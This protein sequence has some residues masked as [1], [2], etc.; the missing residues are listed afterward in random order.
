M[1]SE[2]EREIGSS[3][4]PHENPGDLV[5]NDKWIEGCKKR[6]GTLRPKTEKAK[7]EFLEEATRTLKIGQEEL[8]VKAKKQFRDNY[9]EEDEARIRREEAKI[10]AY[11]KPQEYLKKAEETAEAVLA[12]NGAKLDPIDDDFF[13]ILHI[14]LTTKQDRISQAKRADKALSKISELDIMRT[15]RMMFENNDSIEGLYKAWEKPWGDINALRSEARRRGIREE[16]L[17]I[18]EVQSREFNPLQEVVKKTRLKQNNLC[19]IAA[20]KASE[21][22]TAEMSYQDFCSQY[23]TERGHSIDPKELEDAWEGRGQFQNEGR[24][25]KQI[26]ESLKRRN[27][28]RNVRGMLESQPIKEKKRD[29]A[30]S[31][32]SE[33]RYTSPH[34]PRIEIIKELEKRMN[35]KYH[36]ANRF[37]KI[38]DENK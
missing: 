28:V 29:E 36:S 31:I 23:V 2:F 10:A 34:M 17:E 5:E 22:E 14:L 37:L 20:W 26:Y 18:H 12:K 35:I 27:G 1:S 21:K 16:L 9:I 24:S 32:I 33:I 11:G 8:I 7:H 4:M 3:M 25:G 15:I 38:Y 6:L 30:F 13:D 19:L